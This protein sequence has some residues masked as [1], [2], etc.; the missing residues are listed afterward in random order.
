[1]PLLQSFPHHGG[2]FPFKIWAKI[3]P[4]SLDGL[5]LV[6]W[7]EQ[8]EINILSSGIVSVAKI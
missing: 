8:G 6:V 1:V 4:S 7:S 3:K 5:L 2:L